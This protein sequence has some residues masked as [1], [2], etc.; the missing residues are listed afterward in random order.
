[1][2]VIQL[3]SYGIFVVSI[4]LWQR[5][6]IHYQIFLEILLVSC[7]TFFIFKTLFHYR[8]QRYSI[9]TFSTKGEWLESDRGEQSSW[10]ITDKSRV[11][12]LLLFI[13]LMSPINAGRSKWRLIYKDQVT[14]REF[15]RFCG[16]IFYQQQNPRK[17]H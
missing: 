4:L 8:C 6:I 11:T 3:L 17:I 7:V 1:M 15:R 13:H 12:S 16:A 2:L 10:I 14:E 5:S 9:I